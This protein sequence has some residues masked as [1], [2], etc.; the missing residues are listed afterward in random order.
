[1][2]TMFPNV[3]MMIRAEKG[4]PTDPTSSQARDALFLIF[5]AKYP[6]PMT[7][8]IWNT[9]RTTSMRVVSKALKP[10]S[11][12]LGISSIAPAQSADSHDS[13]EV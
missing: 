8:I 6:A 4:Q 9:F 11:R 10:M 12:I 13:G 1:M 5:V 7:P 2:Q 3:H